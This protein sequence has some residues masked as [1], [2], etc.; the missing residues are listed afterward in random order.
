MPTL[1][2]FATARWWTDRPLGASY[3]MCV[4]SILA[5]AIL[6]WYDEWFRARIGADGILLAPIA[7]S[8]TTFSLF[9]AGS[10]ATMRRRRLGARSPHARC[11]RCGY[12]IGLGGEDKPCP[13]CGAEG[14]EMREQVWLYLAGE[15]KGPMPKT[16]IDRRP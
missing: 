8:L 4:V 2:L 6:L 14:G 13:E 15:L 9:I 1:R 5:C 12:E 7:F 3:T 16:A 10:R 11:Y